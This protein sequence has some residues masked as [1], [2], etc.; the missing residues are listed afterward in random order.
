VGSQGQSVTLQQILY[1]TTPCSIRHSNQCFIPQRAT[2]SLQPLCAAEGMGMRSNC[3]SNRVPVR[4]LCSG[5]TFTP[6][7]KYL[8]PA[9]DLAF[10]GLPSQPSICF[11]VS[12][13]MLLLSLSCSPYLLHGFCGVY[14]GSRGRCL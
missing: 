13:P 9:E 1:F 2:S 14:R 8:G 3:V 5:P 11:P 12:I 6:S 4:R 7:Q 10:L